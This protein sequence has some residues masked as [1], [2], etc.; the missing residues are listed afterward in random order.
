MAPR[1]FEFWFGV[2]KPDGNHSM[3]WKVWG[4]RKTADLY[5]AARS[6]GGEMKAS[7]HAS[8]KRHVGL[9]SEYGWPFF[10]N[11]DTLLNAA[12]FREIP[13]ALGLTNASLAFIR[14]SST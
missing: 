12:E 11:R 4:G 1:P 14:R 3:V 2:G 9:T 7:L 8:G 10:K 5:I 13:N 6:M